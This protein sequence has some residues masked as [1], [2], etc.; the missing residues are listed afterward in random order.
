MII[1]VNP[2]AEV[3]IHQGEKTNSSW[4]RIQASA[5]PCSPRSG[6]VTRSGRWANSV[7]LSEKRMMRK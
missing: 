7:V 6:G 2:L 3:S 1:S 4:P 5:S